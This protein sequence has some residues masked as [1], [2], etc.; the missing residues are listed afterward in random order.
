[1]EL[2]AVHQKASHTRLGTSPH[3]TKSSTKLS[4]AIY[5]NKDKNRPEQ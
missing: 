2:Q 3:P 4:A 5:I 1:M